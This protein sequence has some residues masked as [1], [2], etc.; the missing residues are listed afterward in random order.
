[1]VTV[2]AIGVVVVVAAVVVLA[3]WALSCVAATAFVVVVVLALHH[4]RCCSCPQGFSASGGAT[5]DGWHV[6]AEGGGSSSIRCP[7]AVRG[8]MGKKGFTHC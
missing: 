2:F 5:G 8:E 3:L 4:N 7:A 1:M 6:R